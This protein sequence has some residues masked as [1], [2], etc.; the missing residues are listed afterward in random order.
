ME[1]RIC[2]LQELEVRVEKVWE[3]TKFLYVEQL[4]ISLLQRELEQAERW[5][6]SYE[7]TLMAEDY[8]VGP[9]RSLVLTT[10][11]ASRRSSSSDAAHTVSRQSLS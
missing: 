7:S 10:N 9:N 6:S 4:E 8:G 2:E 11:A 3:E 1:E 5:L